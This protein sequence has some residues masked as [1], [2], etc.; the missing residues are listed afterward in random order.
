MTTMMLWNMRRRRQFLLARRGPSA[1]LLLLLMTLLMT[2]MTPHEHGSS[3]GVGMVAAKMMNDEEKGGYGG[4]G[5]NGGFPDKSMFVEADIDRL[6]KNNKAGKV[7]KNIKGGK[8]DKS[9]KEIDF[10]NSFDEEVNGK[11]CTIDLFRGSYRYTSP[12]GKGLLATIACGEDDDGGLGGDTCRYS[13]RVYAQNACPESG[14]LNDEEEE[15]PCSVGG[16]FKQSENIGYNADT[17]SCELAYFDFS[18]DRCELYLDEGGLGMKAVIHLSARQEMLLRFTSDSGETFYNEEEPRIAVVSS[19]VDQYDAGRALSSDL[20]HAAKQRRLSCEPCILYDPFEPTTPQICHPQ[21]TNGRCG[22]TNGSTSCPEHQPFCWFNRLCFPYKR[23]SPTTYDYCIPSLTLPFEWETWKEDPL[24]KVT[25]IGNSVEMAFADHE[26]CGGTSSGCRLD[27]P[28]RC[29]LG[30]EAIAT[31]TLAEATTFDLL[32]SAAANKYERLVISVNGGEVK[33]ITPEPE[34]IC[35]LRYCAMCVTEETTHQIQ[36]NAGDN[37]IR[38]QIQTHPFFPMYH[39]NAYFRV[40]FRQS[41]CDA[42]C[43]DGSITVVDKDPDV[44]GPTKPPGG[45]AWFEQNFGYTPQICHPCHALTTTMRCGPLYGTC[46]YD[47]PFCIEKSGWCLSNPNAQIDHGQTSTTYDY[48]I[49]PDDGDS[50]VCPF[51]CLGLEQEHSVKWSTWQEDPLSKVTAIGSSVEMK[52]AD[53]VNCGGRSS[54]VRQNMEA[55]IS[56]NYAEA[57]TFDVLWSA[58]TNKRERLL[59]F[60]KNNYEDTWEVIETPEADGNCKHNTCDMCVTEET[61]QQIQLKAGV[62]E[63]IIQLLTAGLYHKDAY[64]RVRLRQSSCDADCGDGSITVGDKDPDATGPK[65]CRWVCDKAQCGSKRWHGDC[66]TRRPTCF[67]GCDDEEECSDASPFCQDGC[68]ATWKEGTQQCN[69]NW[70]CE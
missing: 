63:I 53:H 14:L 8:K 48:C 39:K 20:I 40:R 67:G 5:G 3:S 1:A 58:F 66:Y 41:S 60:V 38:M 29:R 17:H 42:D 23:S 70:T 2:S 49:P 30:M 13:E 31:V 10:P 33:F 4:G 55:R 22:P 24:S 32:W 64:F 61:T 50:A 6:L 16:L 59:I 47:Q 35:E 45:V 65:R 9:K 46:P 34:G 25:A 28:S 11:Q 44:T 15:D 36:L 12:C 21:G 57:T 56:V 26:H 7:V 43:G 54:S 51:C 18:E 62:N 52:F 68:S 69:C 27:S 37:T 19:D